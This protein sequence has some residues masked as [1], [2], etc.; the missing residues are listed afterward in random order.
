MAKIN[1]AK[2]FIN[3]LKKAAKAKKISFTAEL[4]RRLYLI[5]NERESVKLELVYFPFLTIEKR[6]VLKEFGVRIDSLANLM[7]NKIFSAYER[8]EPK[9]IFDLHSYLTK[10]PRFNLMRLIKLAEKKFGVEIEPLILFGKIN[11]LADKLDLLTPLLLKP[12]KNLRKKV[13]SFFQLE[14]NRFAGKRIK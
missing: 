1:L 12:E 11:E 7:A 2:I 10:K 13:K 3:Q 14:F 4:N 9:D 6:K 8:A 5:S